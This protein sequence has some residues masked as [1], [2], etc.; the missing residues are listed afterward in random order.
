MIRKFVFI[1]IFA[2]FAQVSTSNADTSG[3]EELKGSKS[4]NQ[5]TADESKHEIAVMDGTAI[6]LCKDN[7]RPIVVF[8]LFEPGNISRAVAGDQIGSRIS[9]SSWIWH[10]AKLVQWPNS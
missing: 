4:Q 2:I 7:N 6:A 1:V 9:N 3:S 5:N 8:N 10:L